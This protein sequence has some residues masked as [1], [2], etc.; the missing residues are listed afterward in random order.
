MKFLFALF[1]MAVVSTSVLNFYKNS[2]NLS[3]ILCIS[4]WYLIC[5]PFSP[6]LWP[7]KLKKNHN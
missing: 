5:T 4:F 7:E 1:I 2:F 6:L 3:L